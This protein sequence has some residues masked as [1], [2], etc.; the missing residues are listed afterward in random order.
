MFF[1][2]DDRS[3]FCVKEAVS[4]IELQQTQMTVGAEIT[5]QQWINTY[6]KTPFRLWN[7]MMQPFH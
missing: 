7:M 6:K 4:A 2:C 5:K 1:V 3:S